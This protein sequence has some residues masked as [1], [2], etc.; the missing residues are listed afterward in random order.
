MFRPHGGDLV[1]I[2]VFL[3]GLIESKYCTWNTARALLLAVNPDDKHGCSAMENSYSVLQG[4]K[5]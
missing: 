5:A 3:S 4:G 1:F 2:G